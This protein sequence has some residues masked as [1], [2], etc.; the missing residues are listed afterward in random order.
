MLSLILTAGCKCSS[1][2]N[3]VR[4]T[5]PDNKDRNIGDDST[6]DKLI[7]PGVEKRVKVIDE[8]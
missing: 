8:K 5:F 7:D 2:D 1:V 6:S 3:T 4:P